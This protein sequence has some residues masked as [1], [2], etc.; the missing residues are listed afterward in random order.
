MTI[1]SMTT[2][3]RIVIPS[4]IRKRLKIGAGTRFA[5]AE[6]GGKV[7]FQ[8]LTADYF[9]QVAGIVPSKGQ[10]LKKLFRERRREEKLEDAL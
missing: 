10:L 4:A 5:V 2:K 7:I 1:T 8:P 3:G 9:D 6:L